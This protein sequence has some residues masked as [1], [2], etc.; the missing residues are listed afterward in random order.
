MTKGLRL[1]AAAA[2]FCLLFFPSVVRESAP[3]PRPGSGAART[4]EGARPVVPLVQT[5]LSQS[6]QARVFEKFGKLPVP[7]EPNAGQAPADVKYVA[8]GRGYAL[9]LTQTG[10]T[11]AL[12]PPKENRRELIRMEFEGASRDAQ[13]VGAAPQTGKSNYFLGNDPSRWYR[14]VPQFGKVQYHGI[15]PGIDLVYYGNESEL[16]YD[17]VVARGADPNQVRLTF[18][19]VERLRID[20][21][22]LVLVTKTGE[23]R[24]RKPKIYQQAGPRQV[25]VPGHYVVRGANRVSFAVSQ[26]DRDKALVIDP[27]LSYSTYLGGSS[28]D[29]GSDIAVDAS[30]SVY[31]TGG[32]DSSNF[33]GFSGQSFVRAGF[34]TKLSPDGSSR[35]YTTYVGGTGASWAKGIAVDSSFNAYVTGFTDASNFPT[36]GPLQ[37]TN[38][39]GRDGFVAKINPSGNALVYSTYLGGALEDV[40][41]GIAVDSASNAYITGTT[42]STD[43]P[44]ANPIR[45]ANSGSGDAFLAKINATGTALVYSTYIGGSAAESGERVAVDSSNNAYV[46]GSTASTNFPT[47]SPLQST[48]A[49]GVDAFVVKVNPTGSAFSYATYLGGA[50]TD[51]ALS[52]A[53]DASGNAYLTGYTDS[54]NFRTQSPQQASNAGGVDAFVAKINAAGTSL[55]YSTYLGGAGDDFGFGIGVDTAGNAYV[56]GTTSSTSF[57]SS[58]SLSIPQGAGREVFL[59][60]FNA[61]G[62]A[63]SLSL[64]FGGAGADEASGLAVD[65]NGAAYIVGSTASSD[66]PTA[67]P[68]QASNGGTYD[69]FITKI[70]TCDFTFDWTPDSSFEATGS[71]GTWTINV[72][73]TAG[74]SWVATPNA[75]WITVASGSPGN[76][77]GPVT[78]N[79]AANTTASSRFGTVSIAGTTFSVAQDRGPGLSSG[80]GSLVFSATYGANP[81][82]Q[83]ITVNYGSTASTP[84]TA[85]ATVS[86]PTGGNW[87]SVTPVTGNIASGQVTLTVSV[88]VAGLSFNSFASYSGTITVNATGSTNTLSI[89]VTLYVYPPYLS[90]SPSRLAF[91]RNTTGSEAA[92]Q[93]LSISDYYS[94]A[95]PFTA[96]ASTSGGGNWLSVSPTSS[97]TPA[98]LT[99]SVNTTTPAVPPGAYN[100]S[101]TITPAA[102]NPISIPVS[103]VVSG[104]GVSNADTTSITLY[105]DAG[106]DFFPSDTFHVSAS[107]AGGLFDATAQTTPPP[108]FTWLSVSPSSGSLPADLTVNTNPA[109]LAPGTYQGQITI[110]STYGTN[111]PTQTV[112]DVTLIVNETVVQVSP[113]SLQ[114]SYQTGGSAPPSQ[115]VS[116]SL[117]VVS[118]S[119]LFAAASVT[120]PVGSTWLSVSPTSVEGNPYDFSVSVDPTG[121]SP[122]SYTGK[123]TFS[124]GDSGVTPVDVPVTFTV[125]G[126]LLAAN[127]ASVAVNYQVGSGAFGATASASVAVTTG[128]GSVLFTTS[129]SGGGW[130]SVTP[131]SGATPGNLTVTMNPASIT[132]GTYNGN[133][134]VTAGAASNSPL[135]IPVTFTVSGLSAP[136]SL[137]L[138]AFAGASSPAS[139]TFFLNGLDTTL[140]LQISTSVTTP[141][142]GTWLSAV[143]S[144]QFPTV[145]VTANPSGLSA[146]S[147]SGSITLTP[148]DSPS[149][150]V[151]IPV[152]FV[153]SAVPA[154]NIPLT[155]VSFTVFAG[156]A[157][158]APQTLAV[159]STGANLEYRVASVTTAGGHWLT[160]YIAR[161]GSTPDSLNV[162]V[163][164]AGLTPGQY[165]GSIVVRSP[166]DPSGPKTVPVSLTV[167]NAYVVQSQPSALTFSTLPGTSPAAQTLAINISQP[168]DGGVPYFASAVV[169][170]PAG[171]TWLTVTPASGLVD[172]TP[173]TNLTVSVNSASL[174][175]GTY[176]G[177]ILLT[178]SGAANSPFSV[179]V[180]LTVIPQ[181]RFGAG[182]PV[183]P[184]AT[185]V[186]YTLNLGVTGGVPPYVYSVNSPLPPGLTFIAGVISGTP[187][188]F[189]VFPIT[190]AVHDSAP[191]PLQ[192]SQ[193][194][195]CSIRIEPPRLQITSGCPVSPAP[196]G[197]PYSFPLS[198]SGGDG[199]YV[200]AVEIGSLPA[201]LSLRGD[202]IGG[203]PTGPPGTSNFSLSVDS[204]DQHARIDCSMTIT[205]PKLQITSG[206]PGNGTVGVVYTPFPLTATGGGGVGT[207]SFAVVNGNLPAGLS[208]KDGVISG[209]P[210]GPPGISTFSLQV[211]SGNQTATAGPCSVNI[212]APPLSITGTCPASAQ[213]GTPVS[214]SVSASGGTPPYRFTFSGSPWL[215]FNNGT[216]SG[217]PAET[218]NASFSVSVNDSAQGGPK[219]FSCT[220]PVNSPL[221]ITGACPGSGRVGDRVSI[222]LSASG[223]AAPYSWSVSGAAAD[224]L[225]LSAASGANVTLSGIPLKAGTY[226]FTVTLTDS[227]GSP[228][229]TFNCSLIVAE[230]KPPLTVSPGGG[231]PVN[232]IAFQSSVAITF[233][234]SGGTPPYNWSLSGPSWLSLNPTAGASTVVSGAATA[235]GTFTATATATDAEGSASSSCTIV[236]NPPPIPPVTV[237][238]QTP[239]AN[240]Q[241]PVP[242][243]LTLDTPAPVDLHGTVRLTF[244]PSSQNPIDNP[245]VHFSDPCLR[246]CSFTIPAGTK[247]IP[248]PNV[249]RG[250]V[251]GTI[252]I[253][254][255]E[256]FDG[257]RNVLPSPAPFADIVVPAS[258]PVILDVTFDNERADGFDIVISGYSPTRELRSITITFGAAADSTLQGD[259]SVTRDISALFNAFYSSSGSAAGGSMFAGLRIPVTLSGDKTAIGS[260]TVVLTNTQGGS[261]P[262]TKP[263]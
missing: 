127:P 103:L 246:L 225:S 67:A 30:G 167:R 34:V 74:C 53:A 43:F 88:N 105:Y 180:T 221:T 31:V 201:G 158:P 63:L 59:T 219:T 245:Q 122:G 192:Q 205:P 73:T 177:S 159:T 222:A 214:A 9:Y 76:G 160:G 118:S 168:A 260:V 27:V 114:F 51:W 248:L 81:A 170:T 188:S 259:S 128:G 235:S 224:F 61:A 161:S 23:I 66:F 21:G 99:V 172:V 150:A 10:A 116:V 29:F 144:G 257:N 125:T 169:N 135:D 120:T 40:G 77:S 258:K 253:E 200:W 55:L 18:D 211:T 171:G 197:T 110:T 208:L 111:P 179:P 41:S 98:S 193:V 181:L 227:A 204:G 100:G 220:F 1:T 186:P 58:G 206:C 42:L 101:I 202:R 71:G 218:G 136:S 52:I 210:Q 123:V 207:Y 165:T 156:A 142:G 261:D 141:S 182:C 72:T 44:T 87:L 184:G 115:T 157:A 139:Q 163:D 56:A 65:P 149:N 129:S 183:A 164:P 215:S 20:H 75:P 241:T 28:F 84:F 7:F 22:D 152:T 78:L 95:V 232:P 137:S 153:V 134:R 187:S 54:A 48:N 113:S 130:L 64:R 230:A 50:G 97:T 102:G 262:V 60:K 254:V 39:G 148:L 17:M 223:G 140:N 155:P 151:V 131:S 26:Y 109:G 198:A 117:P 92:P 217:T 231:C 249:E 4:P 124:S 89:P 49:G 146:G 199:N 132:A 96:S 133:V 106:S 242:A 189:G 119:S 196:Q 57:P 212:A 32:T 238:V 178:V 203:T 85:S 69:T 6:T 12:A 154:L 244:T 5:A 195:Q 82:N 121:L 247:T 162:A 243:G 213:V 107:D 79:I 14:D 226:A 175:P 91:A 36:V 234:A 255:V 239:P 16:E 174:A 126:P 80:T 147:Y 194:Y 112:V 46:A 86:T 185:G 37:A 256:L 229:A 176:T 45:S 33:P 228:A 237:T 216:V 93:T 24:Q 68:F 108:D 15:Y 19:G 11:I 251:A 143:G 209:T 104:S 25:E 263:R 38:R 13:V 83:N 35:V 8:R 250:T 70:G 190:V 191:G 138:G 173:A 62:S 47:V 166:N 2:F 252:H 90:A 3:R 145:T 94:G 236:V 233:S 240:L